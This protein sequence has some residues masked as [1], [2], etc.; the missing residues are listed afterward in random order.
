[1]RAREIKDALQNKRFVFGTMIRESRSPAIARI[2]TEAGFDFILIDMEHSVYTLE[3]VADICQQAR[4]C[5]L[6][7]V[8][9]VPCLEGGWVPRLLD[10]GADGIMCPMVE[11]IEKARKLVEL[12]KYAPL[13]NRGLGTR[14]GHT[15]FKNPAAGEVMATKNQETILI[16]QIESTL[17]IQNLE[18]IVTTKGLDIALVG[19]M[20]LSVSMGIPGDMKNPDL[21]A[22]IDKVIA[23]AAQAGIAS[24]IH[25]GNMEFLKSCHRKGMT[26]I[27][28]STDI[29]L[30]I[31]S[32]QTAVRKIK[33]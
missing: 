27:A 6:C 30:L 2:M 28:F 14:I 11:T 8:V 1:M 12:G 10:A 23:A 17:G 5:D 18:G 22:N 32:G 21:L 16:A 24:G 15:D 13:G 19:P 29:N 25:T 26:F 31:D 20:D 33:E 3:T 9:R 4:A 7:T